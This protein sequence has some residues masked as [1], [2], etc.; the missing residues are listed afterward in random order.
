MVIMWEGNKYEIVLEDM[1]DCFG[2]AWDNYE[3]EDYN[4]WYKR[5][6]LGGDVSSLNKAHPLTIPSFIRG[7]HDVD[8]V[9]LC[10]IPFRINKEEF[11]TFIKDALGTCD[12]KKGVSYI[13]CA[14]IGEPKSGQQQ[15]VVSRRMRYEGD[16]SVDL[17]QYTNHMR[18]DEGSDRFRKTNVIDGFIYK[19]E[20]YDLDM[21][22]VFRGV[23]GYFSTDLVPMFRIRII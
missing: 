10:M 8:R 21:R 7:Y 11:L 22:S 4:R 6:V 17:L 19:E 18:Q 3:V 5:S 14:E 1:N 20:A 16:T 9:M 2:E 23:P 12:V 13:V 15:K